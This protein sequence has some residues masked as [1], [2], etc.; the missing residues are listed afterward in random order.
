MGAAYLSLPGLA[1]TEAEAN[2]L[3]GAIVRVTELYDV[4]G[5]SEQSRAWINLGIVGSSVYGTRIAAAMMAAKAAKAEAKAA[6]AAK[7]EGGKQGEA[8]PIDAY[9][10]AASVQ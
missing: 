2:N 5:M 8:M 4:P 10:G 9:R 1:L 7:A 6:A 3:A